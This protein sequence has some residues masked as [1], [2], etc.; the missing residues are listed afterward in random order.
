MF[1]IK[2]IEENFNTYDGFPI[3]IIY[4]F[5]ALPPRSSDT[6]SCGVHRNRKLPIGKNFKKELYS[7]LQRGYKMNDDI[8]KTY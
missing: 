7:V 3:I 2:K 5:R 4:I 1:V 6:T 8:L